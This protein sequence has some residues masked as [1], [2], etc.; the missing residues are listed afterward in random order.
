MN[1]DGIGADMRQK[2]FPQPVVDHAFW[3]NIERENCQMRGIQF[4]IKPVKTKPCDGR[5]E[6]HD[7]GDHD[8]GYGQ[9]QK[10]CR[11]ASHDPDYTFRAREV[12]D[13]RWLP[14]VSI[15]STALS[16]P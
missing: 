11:Q 16:L 2:F 1:I 9:D 13:I 5:H 4:L 15:N 6:N 12:P 14:T 7:F 10:A 8:E 3:C